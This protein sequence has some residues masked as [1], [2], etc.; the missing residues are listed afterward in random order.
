MQPEVNKIIHHIL[1]LFNRKPCDLK[2]VQTVNTIY[3]SLFRL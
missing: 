2:C 3:P 1:I